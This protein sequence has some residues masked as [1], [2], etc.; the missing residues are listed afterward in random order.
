MKVRQ[1]LAIAVALMAAAA[2]PSTAPAVALAPV[3]V[4]TPDATMTTPHRDC[5]S[6]ASIGEALAKATSAVED[7]M[8]L[9]DQL[10]VPHSTCTT[11]CTPDL[12]T[13][14]GAIQFALD[15]TRRVTGLVPPSPCRITCDGFGSGLFPL[16]P[17]LVP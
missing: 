13:P 11:S 17:P 3:A 14:Q 6:C 5:T 2:I 10:S 15:I 9:A 12:S 4:E 1:L 16:G 8:K 7:A